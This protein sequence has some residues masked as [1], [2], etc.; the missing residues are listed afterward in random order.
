M[1][2][3]PTVVD[4]RALREGENELDLELTG[5]DLGITNEDLELEGTLRVELL[6]AK[7]SSFV[8][9]RGHIEGVAAEIC[10]LC[11]GPA[12]RP[13]DIDVHLV[14]QE[15]ESRSEPGAEPEDED[16]LY[17]E[18]ERIDLTEPLRQL[19][20]VSVPMVPRCKEDCRGLCPVCGVNLNVAGCTCVVETK[21]PRW[22]KLSQLLED[23]PSRSKH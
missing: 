20:L 6:L 2:A 12:R 9:V 4:L 7:T 15:A 18:R 11:A 3:K 23:P 17:Y 21:D 19:V 8:H 1:H 16:L 5:S 13:F 14:A 22:E 10:G